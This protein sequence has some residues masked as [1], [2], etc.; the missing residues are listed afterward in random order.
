MEM[1]LAASRL[2]LFLIQVVISTQVF[3]GDWPMWRYD[4][5]RTAS[6]PEQRPAELYLQWTRHYSPRE[7]VWD[8]P[9]NHDLMQYDKEFEPI[10]I[11]NPLYIGFNDQDKVVAIN[12]DTGKE[13]WT[14]HADGPVQLPMAYYNNKIYFTSDDEYLY[15]LSAQKGNIIWKNDGTGSQFMQQ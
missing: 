7:M 9:I 10:V 4:A 6:S 2:L 5:K 15:C 12:T 13:I 14:Y 11:G 3:A 1:K 8:D